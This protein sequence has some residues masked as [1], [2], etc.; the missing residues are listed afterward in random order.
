MHEDEI[1]AEMAKEYL[2]NV[3]PM[4]KAF[5]LH[6]HLVAKNLAELGE[7]LA[8]IS[9]DVFAYHVS[10]EKNDLARWVHEVI[11]DTHL[12]RQLQHA[13]NQQEAS[14]LVLERVSELRSVLTEAK[15]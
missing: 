2:A 4:W 15:S 7:G 10:G 8:T 5:W 11:G 1:S 6:M 14:R 9:D 12:A 13:K 3:Q